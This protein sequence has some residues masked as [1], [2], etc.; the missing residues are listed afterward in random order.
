MYLA[1]KISIEDSGFNKEL[2]E[3]T[4]LG[5]IK[6]SNLRNNEVQI[7]SISAK[8]IGEAIIYFRKM[9]LIILL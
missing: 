3:F 8:R 2:R 1:G 9:D 6:L 7:F 5:E 4:L